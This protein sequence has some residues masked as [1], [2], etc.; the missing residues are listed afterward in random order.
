MT[1][2]HPLTRGI[3]L[4]SHDVRAEI[5]LALAERMQ[6]CPRD[7]TLGFAELRKRVGHDDPG[8]FNYHL[9]RLQGNLVEKREGGYRLSD[10]GHH[11]VALLVS[12]RFDPDSKREFPDVETPCLLCPESASVTYEDGM[13]RTSCDNG[14]SSMMNVGP[15]LLDSHSVAET[16]NIAF[17]RT[18]WEAKSTMSGICPYC[19]GET[20][21]A[22][23]RLRDGPIPLLY[24]WT[25]D[26]CGVFLQNSP[27]GCVLFH[28]AVVSFCYQHDVD[29]FQRPWDMM[30]HNVETGTVVSEEP[31]R[32]Q[33]GIALDE[34]RLVLT[35]DESATIIDVSRPSESVA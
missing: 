32:V 18:L 2:G 11:F 21:A 12:G 10:I 29:I 23:N 27:G 24:E 3:E 16:L 20:T 25:C 13:L 22:V 31:L 5:L 19:E 28:P 17:R 6:E 26:R 7:Q 30:V 9:K 4:V 14:H 33:V 1:D 15:E 34:E 8:N 35:L